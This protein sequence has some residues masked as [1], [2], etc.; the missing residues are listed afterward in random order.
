MPLSLRL[1]FCAL[2]PLA[3]LALL[4]YLVLNQFDALL[5]KSQEVGNSATTLELVM[6]RARL[7]PL[8]IQLF[9]GALLG[10]IIVSLG[11]ARALARSG[12]QARDLAR[13]LA[14]GN[15]R[16]MPA[17]V[18]TEKEEPLLQAVQ[19]AGLA[20]RASL[21]EI[22]ENVADL[23]QC[24]AQY[25]KAVDTM[26]SDAIKMQRQTSHLSQAVRDLLDK[27][28]GLFQAGNDM[29]GERELVARKVGLAADL[30]QEID[31]G[32]AEVAERSSAMHTIASRLNNNS[33]ELFA[34]ALDLNSAMKA[35]KLPADLIEK[36][37]EAPR[38]L[39]ALNS[40]L[41]V[42][43]ESMN[44]QHSTIFD[45]L[46]QVHFAVQ[47]DASREQIGQLLK[48]MAHYT[49]EHFTN[50]ESWLTAIGY[51]ELSRQQEEHT[52]LLARIYKVHTSLEAGQEVNLGLMLNF[53]KKELENHI[54]GSDR[55]YGL[56][57]AQQGIYD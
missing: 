37:G 41:N 47:A 25:P 45:H 23:G 44:A 24:A 27:L 56:F 50:E 40:R 14:E 10:A 9:S 26:R 15:L 29:S 57:C 4:S 19:Q 31:L 43:V 17:T 6:A 30:A 32:L 20:W 16:A 39:I 38:P 28:T 48:N 54:A 12:H 2:I 18:T 46:N 13:E 5:V 1:I 7:Q 51:P 36:R 53:M 33:G 11:M 3:C 22:G 21:K 8:I 52:Q 34:I 55:K 35:F 49:T 42:M